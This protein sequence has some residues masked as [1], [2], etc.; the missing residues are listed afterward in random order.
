ME[1]ELSRGAA[2]EEHGELETVMSVSSS[3][4]QS[5]WCGEPRE[6]SLWGLGVEGGVSWSLSSICSRGWKML[7]A[8]FRRKER[9][10]T[11]SIRSHRQ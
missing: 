2:R 9:R 8:R 10:G 3:E 11:R 6:E 7:E 1:R 5:I 4:K